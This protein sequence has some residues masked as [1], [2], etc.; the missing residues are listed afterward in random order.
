MRET[1]L[2]PSKHNQ[3]IYGDNLPAASNDAAIEETIDA[4]PKLQEATEQ[5][6]SERG[7]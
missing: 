2:Q 1:G 3:N 6:G 7:K 5:Q 4:Q